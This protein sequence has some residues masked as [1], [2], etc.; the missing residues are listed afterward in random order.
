MSQ[1]SS[2]LHDKIQNGPL[3]LALPSRDDVSFWNTKSYYR[4]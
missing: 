4:G 3:N 2:N 1:I